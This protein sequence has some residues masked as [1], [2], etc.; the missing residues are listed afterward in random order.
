MKKSLNSPEIKVGDVILVKGGSWLARQI[1]NW[2]NIYRL[3]KG[4]P[5]RKLYNHAAVVVN[6]WGEKY[7]AEATEKGVTVIPNALDYVLFK[8]TLVLTWI[9]PLNQKEQDLFSKTAIKY[10]LEPHRYDFLN[11]FYQ[12]KYILTGKW[13][14]PIGKKAE[15]RLYCTE[16]AAV[17]MDKVRGSFEGQTW[18]KNPLDLELCEEL[19]VSDFQSLMK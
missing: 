5:K 6:L 15:K 8:D 17:C 4:L 10:A 11:F 18:N 3:K 1:Q 12:I 13:S 2:M 16:F 7:I 9:D 19:K 14:G